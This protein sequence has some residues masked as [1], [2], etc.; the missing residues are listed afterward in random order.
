[1]QNARQGWPMHMITTMRAHSARQLP[2][3]IQ[4]E[5]TR[6]GPINYKETRKPEAHKKNPKTG[7]GKQPP[8]PPSLP[9]KT[10]LT[11]NKLKPLAQR[12]PN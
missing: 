1:M 4:E 6:E 9:P 2:S 12:D 5:A 7:G 8:P 10:S 11:K 3:S